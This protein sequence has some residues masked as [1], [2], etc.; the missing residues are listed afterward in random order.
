[1]KFILRQVVAREEEEEEPEI[2]KKARAFTRLKNSEPVQL[3]KWKAVTNML[4]ISC[5]AK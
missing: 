1:L 4:P 3:F 2:Q 5:A